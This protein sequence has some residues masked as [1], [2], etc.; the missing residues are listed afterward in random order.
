MAYQKVLKITKNFVGYRLFCQSWRELTEF[1]DQWCGGVSIPLMVYLIGQGAKVVKRIVSNDKIHCRKSLRITTAE[2]EELLHQQGWGDDEE[3]GHRR[4]AFGSAAVEDRRLRWLA[5]EPQMDQEEREND[6]LATYVADRNQSHQCTLGND[7]CSFEGKVRTCMRL[8]EQALTCFFEELKEVRRQKA[9]G[10]D[11]SRV[12]RLCENHYQVLLKFTEEQQNTEVLG[13]KMSMA[14]TS[15]T[16]R[17]KGT[18]KMGMIYYIWI[19]IP[20]R[21]PTE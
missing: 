5:G 14:A 6:I 18:P 4:V 2:E 19:L 8:R 21:L 13:R 16:V 7:E 3:V 1:C 12:I 9:E 11:T 17:K 15:G 10:E 20:I